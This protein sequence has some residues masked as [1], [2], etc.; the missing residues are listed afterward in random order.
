[1]VSRLDRGP[2]LS[3]R[4]LLL[5]VRNLG[6]SAT[7]LY[8]VGE[9]SKI[10]NFRLN[11]ESRPPAY[12]QPGWN[13][14]QGTPQLVDILHPQAYVEHLYDHQP[15]CRKVANLLSSHFLDRLKPNTPYT[16]EDYLVYAY[17]ASQAT[18][19]QL[20]PGINPPP[21]EV[22]N[23]AIQSLGIFF[24]SDR[25]FSLN[26][27]WEKVPH[28]FPANIPAEKNAGTMEQAHIYSGA[29]RSQHFFSALFFAHQIEYAQKHGLWPKDSH[30]LFID[31]AS[32]FVGGQTKGERISVTL[33]K[34]YELFSTVRPIQSGQGSSSGFNDPY[35]Y[36][37]EKANAFGAVAGSSLAELANQ[38]GISAA[39]IITAFSKIQNQLNKQSQP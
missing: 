38:P 4:E 36:L 34:M 12:P 31:L 14:D 1:M 3:R 19:D 5:R 39:L 11:Q 25:L 23:L 26:K 30:P 22:L 18:L 9:I 2:K 17:N 37:D 24:F 28:V 20:S 29:D 7:T 32:L 16:V 15:V 8:L 27:N 10:T 35:E 6:L 33:G 13:L 21:E